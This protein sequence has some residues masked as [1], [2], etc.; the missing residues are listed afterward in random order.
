MSDSSSSSS[1]SSSDSDSRSDSSS[2]D[3]EEARKSLPVP[4]SGALGTKKRAVEGKVAAAAGAK[5]GS[6][7]KRKLRKQKKESGYG[8]NLWAILQTLIALC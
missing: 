2:S 8:S 6:V 7:S 4:K 5:D 1:S 3:V